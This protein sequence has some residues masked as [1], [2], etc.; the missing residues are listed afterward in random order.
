MTIVTFFHYYNRYKKS[1]LSYIYIKF[2][3]CHIF[4]ILIFMI[5]KI[6]YY[7]TDFI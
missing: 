4:P 3:I 1:Y 2:T 7:F 5:F 6:L